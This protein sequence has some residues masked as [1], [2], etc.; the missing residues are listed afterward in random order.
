MS[1]ELKVT[2]NDLPESL[3]G[4]SV[5]EL[6]QKTTAFFENK[7]SELSVDQA[8]TIL[9]YL[10][11]DEIN[12]A[13]AQYNLA[14]CYSAGNGIEKDHTKAFEWL[15]KSA[16]QGNPVA[17]NNVAD[18]YFKGQGVEQNK[19]KGLKYVFSSVVFGGGIALENID[20]QQNS[21]VGETIIPIALAF[22]AVGRKV[23]MEEVDTIFKPYI[24]SLRKELG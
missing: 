8:V 13:R 3:R 1:T 22:N 23:S 21:V 6:F 11:Q 10:S 20:Y 24:H 5:E 15:Q 16:E 9:R 18:C 2:I 14:V 12:H 4:L 7:S 19:V 17:Q